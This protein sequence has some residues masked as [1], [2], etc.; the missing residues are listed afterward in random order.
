[1]EIYLTILSPEV[2]GLNG[3]YGNAAEEL[4]MALRSLGPQIRVNEWPA[5]YDTLMIPLAGDFLIKVF[6]GLGSLGLG[7]IV[8]AWL[9]AKHGRKVRVKIGDIEAEAQTAAE[10]EKLLARA[11]EMQKSNQSKLIHEP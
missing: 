5:V 9:Q 11:Q 6:Q 4:E 2:G 8:G 1:M 10:V 7:G 3:E